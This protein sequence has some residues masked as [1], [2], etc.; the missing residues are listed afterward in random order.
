MKISKQVQCQLLVV[1]FVT[2]PIAS[3]T[4]TDDDAEVTSPPASHGASHI[5][6]ILVVI[7]IPVVAMVVHTLIVGSIVGIIRCLCK[8]T[9]STSHNSN[10]T[11]QSPQQLITS[12]NET[13]HPNPTSYSPNQEVGR[14]AAINSVYYE[15]NDN[16]YGIYV[17]PPS[18][19]TA[20][21]LEDSSTGLYVIDNIAYRQHRHNNSIDAN[22]YYITLV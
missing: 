21:A 2:I 20:A 9:I 18:S 3:G 7:A 11:T 15:H 10:T 22:D 12:P 13:H 5:V 6:V 17:A 4:S 16:S 8:N 19:N 14:R 1:L